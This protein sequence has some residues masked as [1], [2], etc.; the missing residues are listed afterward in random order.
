MVSRAARISAVGF[1]G[2]AAFQVAAA[3]G[4]PVGRF[5]WGGAHAG[6]LPASLR[7]GS[8][9]SAAILITIA[10]LLV[11]DPFGDIGRRRLLIGVLAFSCLSAIA[12]LASPSWRE[13]AVWAPFALMQIVLMVIALR[14]E[15]GGSEAQR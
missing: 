12:N 10:V 7:T 14:G 5:A 11:R 3:A 6:V 2:A 8:A 15:R 13:R 9:V 4:A 1:A